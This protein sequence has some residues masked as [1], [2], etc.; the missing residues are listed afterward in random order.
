MRSPKHSLLRTIRSFFLNGV[1]K[2]V[3]LI[4]FQRQIARERKALARLSDDQL[5]DIGVSQKDALHES[6]RSVFEIPAN[7]LKRKRLQRTDLAKMSSR[8]NRNQC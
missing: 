7:R 3:A 5:R 6:G 2:S 1:G 4:E 8:P